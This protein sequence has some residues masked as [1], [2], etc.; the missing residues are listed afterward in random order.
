MSDSELMA[1]LALAYAVSV[2]SPAN[3]ELEDVFGRPPA[4]VANVQQIEAAVR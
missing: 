4:H 1:P 2:R 3:A